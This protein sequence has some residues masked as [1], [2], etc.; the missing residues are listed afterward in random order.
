MIFSWIIV[1][2]E[3]VNAGWTYSALIQKEQERA[4]YVH[5]SCPVILNLWTLKE[6]I[7][8]DLFYYLQFVSH[9]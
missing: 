5:I 3:E 2:F 8:M 7:K 9:D 1:D 6:N 4:I